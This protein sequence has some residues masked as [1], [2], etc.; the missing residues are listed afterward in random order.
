MLEATFSEGLVVQ[1]SRIMKWP[2]L[3][4]ANEPSTFNPVPIAPIHAWRC[5][6]V[7]EEIHLSSIS[8]TLPNHW[9][10]ASY[11]SF[12]DR[13]RRPQPLSDLFALGF[14]LVHHSSIPS[15]RQHAAKVDDLLNVDILLLR[16]LEDL[17]LGPDSNQVLAVVMLLD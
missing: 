10:T 11:Q 16:R 12:N 2:H 14:E 7:V 3:D 8:S 6:K 9:T 13:D 17:G 5:E 15:A 1:Q 4:P